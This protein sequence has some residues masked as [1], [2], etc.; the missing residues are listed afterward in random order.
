M[1]KVLCFRCAK[2]KRETKSSLYG[3]PAESC[4]LWRLSPPEF[5]TWEGI[6]H[7]LGICPWD[8]T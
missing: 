1:K 6:M 3:I 8:D 4:Q 7:G 5:I 2:R